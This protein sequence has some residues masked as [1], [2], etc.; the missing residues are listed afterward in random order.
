MAGALAHTHTLNWQ[1]LKAC[2]PHFLKPTWVND[3]VP[4][5]S[6]LLPSRLWHSSLPNPSMVPLACMAAQGCP[7]SLPWLQMVPVNVLPRKARMLFPRVP[8][9]A[10]SLMW[11]CLVS[12]AWAWGSNRS[13]HLARLGLIMPWDPRDLDSS[14]CINSNN[15]HQRPHSDADA[16]DLW[17]WSLPRIPLLHKWVQTLTI[18]SPV[19]IVLKRGLD[20]PFCMS[21]LL[22]LELIPTF[23]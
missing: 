18:I 2:P 11:I 4:L 8:K 1:D 23:F 19:H 20:F 12:C 22:R 6:H 21:S 15:S 17:C 10:R 5:G 13:I 3:E 14:Y 7:S 9:S 16:K